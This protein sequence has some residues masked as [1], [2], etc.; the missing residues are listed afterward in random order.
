MTRPLDTT[1]F[2][3]EFG[4]QLE[5]R[6][7]LWLRK[8]FLWYTGTK[9]GIHVV[10]FVG[11]IIQL[12]STT[13]E[14]FPGES[15]AQALGL[16]LNVISLALIAFAFVHVLR[17]RLTR[18][19]LLKIVFW[20]IVISGSLSILAG[21]LISRFVQEMVETKVEEQQRAREAAA[22]TGVRA[23]DA[24]GAAAPTPP[25]TR[26]AEG[27]TIDTGA[28]KPKVADEDGD[29]RAQ[30]R[31][32]RLVSTI[33]T[34]A[35]GLQG[36]T[37]ILFSHLFACFFLPWKPGESAKPFLPLLALN[38]IITIGF[39]AYVAVAAGF[40][41]KTLG[42]GLL[43][44]A[45]SPLALVPGLGICYWR[46]SRFSEEYTGKLMRGRYAEMRRE[47]V[48]ARRIHESLF[49]KPIATGPIRLR[50]VYE[51]M[52]QIG[53]DYLFAFSEPTGMTDSGAAG[54]RLS[55][56]VLDVTGHG[57]AAALTVNR[58]YGELSRV[59]AENPRTSPGDVLRLLN[60]YIHLTLATHS[61]YVTAFCAR[62]DTHADEIEYA[63]GGHPPAYIR[64][65]DATIHQL[66]STTFVLG[67]CADRDFRHD[68]RTARFMP[69]DRL[70]ALTDGALEARPQHG[71]MLGVAGLE[72]VLASTRPFAADGWPLEILRAVEGYR[73][74]PPEDDTLIIEIARPPSTIDEPA[75]EARGGV[76]VAAGATT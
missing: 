62:V 63:S 40:A 51:P 23:P 31:K 55:V 68:A 7:Q 71:R 46:M 26:R 74:S 61:V 12:F 38:A 4:S 75:P 24:P 5:Q 9:L 11:P 39:L 1:A 36:I 15:S 64:G 66:P 3:H 49:P 70:I 28:M 50:Y 27:L 41:W 72:R 45:I 35:Q 37:T 53:G 43:L 58:L 8:R 48:D 10:A 13:S 19:P 29:E 67:A 52:R 60:K 65:A 56:V 22:P 33:G 54:G 21:P 16:S 6:R 2:Q 30:R 73:Q 76:F 32:Q 69:G 59:F 34:M 20:L 44:V 47:L 42:L 17:N 25:A 14:R 18:W 57:I